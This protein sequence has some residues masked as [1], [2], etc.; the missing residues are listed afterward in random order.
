MKKL[1]S[2]EEAMV[3]DLF[4]NLKHALLPLMDDRIYG[5]MQD[6]LKA[7]DDRD[8]SKKRPNHS[9]DAEDSQQN[10]GVGARQRKK[11]KKDSQANGEFHGEVQAPSSSYSSATLAQSAI[12]EADVEDCGD[13]EQLESTVRDGMR[14]TADFCA[15]CFELA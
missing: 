10:N 15:P 2:Q 13:S 12:H 11:M 8:L 4:C 6:V 9:A 3:P 7:I 1:L 5:T 14:C